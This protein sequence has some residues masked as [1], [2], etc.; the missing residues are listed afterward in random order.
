MGQW[1]SE[2]HG[3]SDSLPTVNQWIKTVSKE[4]AE[5]TRIVKLIWTPNMYENYSLDT[6][7]FRL[8]VSPNHFLFQILEDNLEDWVNADTV[9]ALEIEK[10]KIPK[11]TLITLDDEQCEWDV[12]GE[13]GFKAGQVTAKQK[14]RVSKN[15]GTKFKAGSTGPGK[16]A[17]G[18]SATP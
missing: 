7:A 6:E 12:L 8:R 1:T 5:A 10:L 16:P 14:K 3:Q 17:E 11:V 15:S 13:N 9:L 2:L 4:C 18:P